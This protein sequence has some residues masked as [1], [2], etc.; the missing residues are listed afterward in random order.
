VRR[1]GRVLLGVL[2]A[3]VLAG[4]GGPGLP[5]GG[6]GGDGDGPPKEVPPIA[7]AKKSL[8]PLT[9]GSSWAYR[10]VDATKGTFEK[11]VT[12]LG[13]MDV[14][15]TQGKAIAVKSVQP[16]LEELS[17]QLDQD[18]MV[19]RVREEDRKDGAVARVTVWTP[20]TLKA[21]SAEK[22]LGWHNAA[23][24]HEIERLGDGS[25]NSEKDK[26]YVWTVEAVDE[27]VVVPAGNFKAIKVVRTRTDKP[28]YLRTYWLVPGIGKVKE[29]GERLEELLRYDIK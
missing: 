22:P 26:T 10:I 20:S 17:W 12:V 21:I 16:Y 4:C 19:G 1:Q 15:D 9:T 24:T 25:L 18:G 5:P 28:D 3:A 23:T 13:P 7:D 14:P 11:T 2:A 29:D 8:W 27:Q 6:G